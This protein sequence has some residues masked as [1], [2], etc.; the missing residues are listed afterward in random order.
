MSRAGGF[1]DRFSED[2]KKHYVRM[3]GA[4]V[5]NFTIKVVPPLIRD[6]LTLAGRDA[7]EI[8][9][10]IFHQSN[11][12]IIQHLMS[13]CSLPA[14]RVPMVLDRFGNPGGPSV[15]LAV[16]QGIPAAERA[17]T[18]RLMLLGYGVGLSWASAVVPLTPDTFVTH[19]DVPAGGAVA[20]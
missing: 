3:N 5:F 11:R 2:T 12:F 18:L 16:T 6:A 7:T 9:Y 14:E 1:R 10:Y 13:K 20:S 19:I 4:N 8:D 15:P 17:R